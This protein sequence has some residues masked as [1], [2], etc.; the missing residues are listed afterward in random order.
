MDHC[1]VCGNYVSGNSHVCNVCLKKYLEKDNS[2]YEN[3]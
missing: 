2:V 1:V 3:K